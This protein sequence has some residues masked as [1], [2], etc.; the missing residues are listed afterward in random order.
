MV[1]E[2]MTEGLRL[3]V[4]AHKTP[5]LR[6]PEEPL[7]CVGCRLGEP[8]LGHGRGVPQYAPD[9]VGLRHDYGPP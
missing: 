7:E 3:P 8:S 1:V 9:R 2:W 6:V 4:N 5:Y